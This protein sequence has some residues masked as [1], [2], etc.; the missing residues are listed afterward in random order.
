MRSIPLTWVGAISPYS[1]PCINRKLTMKLLRRT[2]S[3]YCRYH[4][5]AP[6]EG[7]GQACRQERGHGNDFCL[8]G[9][10]PPGIYRGLPSF[11]GREKSLLCI[12]RCDVFQAGQEEIEYY[13][14]QYRPYDKAGAYGIQE[15]IG[16]IAVEN[17]EEVISM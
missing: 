6:G 8:I 16:H 15:W 5:L 11:A 10:Y 13:V 12:D 9:R 7:T 17:I 14:D 3:A 1:W 4:C 2:R